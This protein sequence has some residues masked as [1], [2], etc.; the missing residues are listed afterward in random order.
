MSEKEN[1]PP[2]TNSSNTL[3][4]DS[5]ADLN[6]GPSWAGNTEPTKKHSHE[7]V[8]GKT[9][10]FEKKERRSP[11]RK[12]R[13]GSDKFRK[14]QK[15]THFSSNRV[16]KDF[17][18]PIK[19][20]KFEVK[21]Y[22]QDDTFDALVKQLKANF[23]T[24]QLFGITRTILEKHER[25]VVLINRIKKENDA[26][27]PIFFTPKDNM[28]F[29]TEADAIDHYCEHH[30]SDFFDIK[31]VDRDAPKGN[32]SLIYRC[33]FTKTLIGPPNYHRYQ[34]LLKAHHKAK[35]KNL[36][37]EDYQSKLE[38][39][40]DEAVVSE[41]LEQMK[42]GEEFCLKSSGTSQTNQG[43]QDN[44]GNQNK[45]ELEH[46]ES[47]EFNSELSAE[48]EQ[49]A[50]PIP[51]EESDAAK[52][53]QAVVDQAGDVAQET[54]ADEANEADDIEVSETTD[55]AED[56]DNRSSEANTSKTFNTREAAK[57]FLIANH[58]DT[59]V[60]AT[61]SF[62]FSGSDINNLPRGSIKESILNAIHLQQRFPLDTANNI[63][64]RLRRHKFTIYKKGPK[65]ISFVCCVKRK[66]RDETT[67]FTDS[68]S[69]LI[70]YIEAQS[71]VNVQKL[72][73]DFLSIPKPSEGKSS[74]ANNS[75]EQ[76]N[77]SDE[78]SNQI[79]EV[80]QNLRWLISEGYVTEYSDGTLFVHPQL[81][82][83]NPKKILKSESP[84]KSQTDQ[85]KSVTEGD[86]I[87][88]T[89][90]LDCAENRAVSQPT[91]AIETAESDI[92]EEA[93]A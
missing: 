93:D 75:S 56:K 7:Q 88:T 4:L 50:E 52:E 70:E 64:G 20:P 29:D 27:K 6:F 65:G 79:K 49:S 25:L 24:Y 43:N 36:S 68:I 39:I 67:V 37:L 34:D 8:D 54:V 69:K 61:H 85:L 33:P 30:L 80:L 35:I 90:D 62:R 78:S 53:S 17:Q 55:T 10:S 19:N 74:D 72:P 45:A 14:Q 22:P 71:S 63:R 15:G 60:K 58:K 2:T 81:E 83:S 84:K 76:E 66:F 3:D 77:L 40:N 41:W 38:G 42:R 59:I 48:P 16:H 51:V 12:D 57:R 32:F 86:E 87:N 92:T 23:R 28:P 11:A 47:A 26:E 89:S 21:I 44:Q 18:A 5:L 91:T 31:T 82:A 46:K 9:G 73:Y 1:N 13:R